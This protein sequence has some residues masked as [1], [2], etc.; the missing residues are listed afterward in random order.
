MASVPQLERFVESGVV[1]DDDGVVH[2]SEATKDALRRERAAID[3]LDDDE[4]LDLV[5]AADPAMADALATGPEPNRAIAAEFLA[6]RT[7]PIDDEAVLSLLVLFDHFT[8]DSPRDDGA[9]DA[10][11]PIHGDRLVALAPRFER[12]IAYVWRDDCPPCDTVR[13]DLDHLLPEPP[14]DTALLATFGPRHPALLHDAYDVLGGPT[15]LFLRS[16]TPDAR[17]VGAVPRA[18]VADEIR[19]LWE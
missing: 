1:E 3:S 10:F 6:L 2:L 16:G 15:T 12:A 8:D 13:G 9:P 18:S 4:V 5:A 17:L 7:F 11:L 19:R 14:D